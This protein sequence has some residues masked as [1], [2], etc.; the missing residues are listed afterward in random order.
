MKRYTTMKR[1]THQDILGYQVRK[2]IF[3]IA[4]YAKTLHSSIRTQTSVTILKKK[5]VQY[6]AHAKSCLTFFK[7]LKK[8]KQSGWASPLHWLPWLQQVSQQWPPPPSRNQRNRV[9]TQCWW[10]SKTL[11][12][13]RKTIRKCLKGKH[14][15]AW[16]LTGP[17]LRETHTHKP[18][19]H[20][21][22]HNSVVIMCTTR[23]SPSICLRPNAQTIVCPWDL[24]S[25]VV[26]V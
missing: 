2:H 11:Q 7:Q 14:E 9:L 8:C 12:P 1:Y 22:A 21:N 10:E 4:G 24:S 5:L 19:L 17:H 16:D 20:E 26:F 15:R 13:F 18:D 25:E 23:N 3:N 6:N